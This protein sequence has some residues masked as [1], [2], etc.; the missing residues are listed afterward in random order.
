MGWSCSAI[1]GATLDRFTRICQDNFNN[2]NTFSV[3]GIQYFFETSRKEHD[4]GSITGF[5]FKMHPKDEATFLA[6]KVGYFKIDGRT[7]KVLRGPK[8]FKN[9]LKISHRS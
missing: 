9:L 5:V 6:Y 1:A 3:S 7:G 2:S 4:D 8:I